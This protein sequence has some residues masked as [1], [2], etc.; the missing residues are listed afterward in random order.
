MDIKPLQPTI[1]ILNAEIGRLTS[2]RDTLLSL[3]V[4]K[5]TKRKAPTLSP[6]GRKKLADNMRKRWALKKKEQRAKAKT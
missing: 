1:D 3:G 2:A 6:E 4:S 5:P